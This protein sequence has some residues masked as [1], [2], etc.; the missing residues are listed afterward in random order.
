MKKTI[1]HTDSAPAAVGPYSQAVKAGSFVY[2]SGQLGLDPETGQ[3]VEGGVAEQARQAL[4]NLK[5]VLEAAGSSLDDVVKTTV[6][7]RLIGDYAAVNEIYA[8]F[9]GENPPARSAFAVGALPLKGKVEI[10]AVAII[11]EA[12]VVAEVNEEE[13]PISKP[14]KKKGKKGK[15]GKKKK[16]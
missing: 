11:P 12:D 8:E 15:K 13:E 3:F 9:F 2:T 5:A 16:D 10:E 4:T 14:K 7:L 6:F 1:V